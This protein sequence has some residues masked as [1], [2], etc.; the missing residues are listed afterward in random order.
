ML[1][2]KIFLASESV[3]LTYNQK[4]SIKNTTLLGIGRPVLDK[5]WSWLI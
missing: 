5:P 4:V 3:Q 1:T 2:N